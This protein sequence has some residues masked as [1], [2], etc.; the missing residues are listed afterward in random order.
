MA[1][2]AHYRFKNSSFL[3]CV[4]KF[5]SYTEINDNHSHH[6]RTIE[7]NS[8]LSG[9]FK[10]HLVLLKGPLNDSGHHICGK[11]DKITIYCTFYSIQPVGR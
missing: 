1:V 2:L 11:G 7:Q 3:N 5:S 8:P 4:S 9:P 10:R 6:V